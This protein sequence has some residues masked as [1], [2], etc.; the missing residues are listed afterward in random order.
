MIAFGP[1]PSRRLGQSLGVNNI[2]PKSCLY[3][4]VYCQLGRVTRM[5]ADREAYYAPEEILRE[6]EAR[7]A[8]ARASGEPID[9]LT[10]VADGEPTLDVHLGREI[11]M[12]KGL[13]LPVAVISNA[14]M[15]WREDVREELMQADWVSL[16]MDAMDE[17]TWGRINRPRRNL[18]LAPILEGALAFARDFDGCLAT[19]TMLMAGLNDGDRQLDLVARFLAELSPETA[20]LAISTRPPAEDWVKPPDEATLVRAYGI[21]SERVPQV[22]YLIGYEGDAFA[23]SGDLEQDLLSI[24]AVH[25]MRSDAVEILIGRTGVS[26]ESVER[27]V[28]AGQLLR[29]SYGGH[30]F[31]ARSLG[32][33]GRGLGA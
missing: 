4:C 21:L 23:A 18:S 12:L 8:G 9:Y 16:K 13:G 3:S 25:P 1:V 20:Y 17:E 31:Y 6:V 32:R 19:E 15:I 33:Y 2:P 27:M 28:A 26:W 11:A 10:F 22:E 7:V 5:P 30:T 24:T 29:L 14:S